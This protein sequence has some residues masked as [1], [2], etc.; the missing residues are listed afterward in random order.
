MHE[1]RVVSVHMLTPENRKQVPVAEPP[2]LSLGL[3]FARD[4]GAPCT[5]LVLAASIAP[6]D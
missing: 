5:P 3:A 1:V 4:C 2:L 6:A